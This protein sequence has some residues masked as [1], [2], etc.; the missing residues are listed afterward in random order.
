MKPDGDRIL[1]NEQSRV[2]RIHYYAIIVIQAKYLVTWTKIMA[3]EVMSRQ[4][5][6]AC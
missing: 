3:T 5:L 2:R 6:D 4:V 1:E